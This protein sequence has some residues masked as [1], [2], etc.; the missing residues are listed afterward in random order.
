M[1]G[2]SLGRRVAVESVF[3]FAL[4]FI[5]LFYFSSLNSE[6]FWYDSYYH[7]KFAFLSRTLGLLSEFP[8]AAYSI[9]SDA[10][11]DKEFLYHILLIP[12]TLG[13]DLMLGAKSSAAFFG[14]GVFASFYA[15]L[16]LVG[17]GH[18]WLWTLLLSTAGSY[19]LMRLNLTRPHV[20]SVSLA[21]WTI[22]AL[23]NSRRWF[24]FALGVIYPL[25]YTAFHLPI[26]L[27]GLSALAKV[28]HLIQEKSF[29]LKKLNREVLLFGTLI[30]GVCISLLFHPYGERILSLFYIQNILIPFMAT[31]SE[32][33][34]RMGTEFF[35]LS[36][37]EYLQNHLPLLIALAMVL[38]RKLRSGRVFTLEERK[39]F[40][41]ACFFI[42]ISMVTR[43]FIE[44]SIPAGLLF[45]AYF[46][47]DDFQT[48][49]SKKN[50]KQLVLCLTIPLL[51]WF[52]WSRTSA[53]ASS[54]TAPSLKEAALFLN[55]NTE[56]KETVF[57]CDWDDAPQLFF[58]NHKNQYLVFLDPVFMFVKDSA[59]WSSWDRLTKG[60]AEKNPSELIKR[61]FN[62]R[63]GVCTSNFSEFKTVLARDPNAEIVFEN[64]SSFVFKLLN[65]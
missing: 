15:F 61:L 29:E 56:D 11:A 42:F 22:Y 19:F 12:F 6:L 57:T 4:G 24:L 48:F 5:I 63:W 27:F 33:N 18:A 64:E 8:W 38:I 58:Y 13:D 51:M 60:K 45:C 17:V 35:A 37:S 20:L 9:W 23:L 44:Y 31:G 53:V 36:S 39:L 21:I 7:I 26:I 41:F 40:L 30:F 43:R 47:R 32:L 52:G 14:A 28:W 59:L 46:L 54:V 65:Q 62:A 10:F 34:L 25:A 49:P 1:S 55:E 2:R 3:I 50:M 16:R